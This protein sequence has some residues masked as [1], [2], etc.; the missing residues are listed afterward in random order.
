[1]IAFGIAF[2]GWYFRPWATF[3]LSLV[4]CSH[5]WRTSQQVSSSR[6][7]CSRSSQREKCL[8]RSPSSSQK[9]E[10][11]WSIMRCCS[12]SLRCLMKTNSMLRIFSSCSDYQAT[13]DW[14][15]LTQVAIIYWL[16]THQLSHLVSGEVTQS[17][18]QWRR[19][20]IWG[21]LSLPRYRKRNLR[22]MKSTSVNLRN[23]R[24]LFYRVVRS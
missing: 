12:W 19:S 14:S 17:S 2:L 23:Q 20:Q 8:W 5:T 22:W 24:R 6:Q 21:Y 7:H 10:P 3:C 18:A 16:P 4:S 13:C 15:F 11:R 9:K 1:M